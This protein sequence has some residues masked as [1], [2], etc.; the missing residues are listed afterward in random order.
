MKTKG[1]EFLIP[2]LKDSFIKWNHP[3]EQPQPKILTFKE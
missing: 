1:L 2:Y 3:L